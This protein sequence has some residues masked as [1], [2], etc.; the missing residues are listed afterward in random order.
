MLTLPFHR[1]S[2]LQ[3]AKRLRCAL[4]LVIPTRVRLYQGNPRPS[5]PLPFTATKTNRAQA[6]PAARS[7]ARHTN[8][9]LRQGAGLVGFLSTSPPLAFLFSARRFRPLD[10]LGICDIL[11]EEAFVPNGL[12]HENWHT[13]DY[14]S[15]SPSCVQDRTGYFLLFILFRLQ[16]RRR[17]M[18]MIILMTAIATIA[19]SY[20]LIAA[21]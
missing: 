7:R 12:P 19:V 13:F 8:R 10:F 2:R 4:R 9:T 5:A 20:V 21:A 1:T 15:T 6:T 16:R 17:I 14:S 3:Q 11:K 18:S